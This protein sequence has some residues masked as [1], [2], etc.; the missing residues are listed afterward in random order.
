MATLTQ[1]DNSQETERT[2]LTFIIGEHH[3][4]HHIYSKQMN[5]CFC[6][7]ES[8]IIQH[9][10]TCRIIFRYNDWRGAKDTYFVAQD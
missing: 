2:Q 5:S 3:D 7:C 8:C 4:P 1:Q 6:S 10:L 9:E